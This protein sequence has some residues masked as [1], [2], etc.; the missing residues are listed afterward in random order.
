MDLSQKAQ[1][2]IRQGS[3]KIRV[4][5]SGMAQ[6]ITFRVRE[7]SYGTIKYVEIFTEKTIDL[8]NLSRIASE[9]GLPVSAQN[10]R[11][12]PEGKGM[13]DFEVGKA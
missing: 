11:A 6:Q 10:G 12:F 5:R 8:S 3:I 13:A 7:S 2:V 4:V 9:I 1:D